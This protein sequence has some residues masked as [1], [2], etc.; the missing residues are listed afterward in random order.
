MLTVVE[1]VLLLQDVDVFQD[2]TS[3]Q[4]ALVAAIATEHAYPEK[5]IVYQQDELADAMYVVVRGLIRLHRGAT[6]VARVGSNE[7]FGTWALFQDE[8]RLTAATAMERTLLLRIER[9]DFIEVLADHVDVTRAIL[10]SV[11]RRLRAMLGRSA[12]GGG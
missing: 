6:E 11:A 7:A 5:A 10:G 3:E 2:A 9:E 4:V 1:R 12:A 8:P